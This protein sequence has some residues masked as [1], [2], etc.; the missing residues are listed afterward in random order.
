MVASKYPTIE[1]EFHPTNE[2]WKF[3][4]Q[5]KKISSTNM[6]S[7]SEKVKERFPDLAFTPLLP[8][9]KHPVF[10]YRGFCPGKTNIL[11]RGHVKQ[12]GFQAFRV[13]VAWDQD[14]AIEMRD[15]IKIYA[16]V[17]RPAKEGVKVPAIIAWSPYGKVGTGCQDYDHMGPWRM[18][19]PYPK[20][21]GYETFEVG[22]EPVL[23]SINTQ[24]LTRLKSHRAQIQRIGVSGVTLYWMLMLGAHRTLR[25][26]YTFGVNR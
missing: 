9:D 26:T 3:S 2:C 16:D 22:A 6:A 17:F 5:S 23:Q 4:S 1:C 12:P 8:P 24:Y 21:S 25:E 10:T 14:V 20:L 13:D 7:V 18:G 15:G 19:I 11:P